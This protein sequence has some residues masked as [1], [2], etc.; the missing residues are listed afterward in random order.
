MTCWQCKCELTLAYEAADYSKK[1]FHCSACERW[2]EMKK[3]REK[4]NSSVPIK[5]F[6]LDSPPQ[7]SKMI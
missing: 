6:E 3:D 2:Y 1:F 4:V 7:I 5:F